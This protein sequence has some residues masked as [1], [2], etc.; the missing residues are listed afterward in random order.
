MR[1]LIAL[2]L[3]ASP[4]IAD[5]RIGS[6]VL[7]VH[8]PDA[9][10][11]NGDITPGTPAEF[12]EARKRRPEATTLILASHGGDLNTAIRMGF[13]LQTMGMATWV[14]RGSWC[15]SACAVLFFAGSPR[16]VDGELGV[17]QPEHSSQ[18]IKHAT[19]RSLMALGMPPAI[20]DSMWNTPHTDIYVLS[21]DELRAFGLR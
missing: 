4:A 19:Y 13:E 10:V 2:A 16:I 17:H 7:P 14:M 11:L 1:W 18:D 12:E 21:D 15:A 8:Y 5:E 6:F 3:L 20:F 9:I